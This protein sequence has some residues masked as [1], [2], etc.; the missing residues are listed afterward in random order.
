MPSGR[1]VSIPTLAPSHCALYHWVI[2][3]LR[4]G[5]LRNPNRGE[6][7]N[8]SI[9]P[10]KLLHLTRDK[11]FGE[12][13]SRLHPEGVWQLKIFPYNKTANI[14]ITIGQCIRCSQHIW[15]IILDFIVC[16]YGFSLLHHI[17]FSCIRYYNCIGYCT[18]SSWSYEP[19]V[20][21]WHHDLSFRTVADMYNAD[22]EALELVSFN[23]NICTLSSEAIICID[24]QL[25]AVS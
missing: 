19:H 23:K 25:S 15:F 24:L 20:E 14:T 16:I 11:Q 1:N 22:G 3:S 21:Y 13:Y 12:S 7:N 9:F 17:F 2:P 4:S 6:G 5:K 18:R 8:V 10:K